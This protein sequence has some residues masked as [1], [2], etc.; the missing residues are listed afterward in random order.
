MPYR[1]NPHERAVHDPWGN[2]RGNHGGIINREYVTAQAEIISY[3]GSGSLN[4]GLWAFD[5]PRLIEHNFSRF[6][7]TNSRVAKLRR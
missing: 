1:I 4:K 5:K 7:R 2:K 6:I 3:Y